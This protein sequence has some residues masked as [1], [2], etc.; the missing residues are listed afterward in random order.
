MYNCKYG[1][2]LKTCLMLTVSISFL[3]ELHNSLHGLSSISDP[4]VE[5]SAT[6]P[7]S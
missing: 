3:I 6:P 2:N 4:T 7:T 1:L 5:M